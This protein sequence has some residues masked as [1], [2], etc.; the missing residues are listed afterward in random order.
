MSSTWL[1]WPGRAE[2][3]SMRQKQQCYLLLL[4][5][6]P[7]PA[8]LFTLK[9]LRIWLLPSFLLSHT[10]PF[11]RLTS[12]LSH[13]LVSSA[14]DSLFS[15]G[16]N[17]SPWSLQGLSAKLSKSWK[18]SR[19]LPS[20]LQAALIFLDPSGGSQPPE[21]PGMVSLRHNQILQRS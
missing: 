13:M 17:E 9:A 16:P 11:P 4:L 20:H 2:P 12:M 3:S 19:F 15:S 7:G 1:H 8:R 10:L 5:R 14:W 21:C 6:Q 18:P